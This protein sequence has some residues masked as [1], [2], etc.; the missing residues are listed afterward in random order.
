[1]SQLCSCCSKVTEPHLLLKCCICLQN[2]NH[3]CVNITA[4]ETRLINGKKS[5][6][7]TC[8]SCDQMG[9]DINSLKAAIVS[10]QNQLKSITVNN[11]TDAS[12]STHSEFQ[13]EEIVQEVVERQKRQ[14]NIIIF[15][16]KEQENLPKEDRIN[17]EKE[18]VRNILYYISPDV[19]VKNIQRL[20]KYDN[21]SSKPRLVKVSLLNSEQAIQVLR[22]SPNLKKNDNLK[23]IYLSSDQT[24]SQISYYKKVKSEL[25]DRIKAGE[26]NL[27]IKHINGIPKIVNF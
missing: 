18:D 25:E 23:N 11:V 4:S 9:S 21:Q 8:S 15:G 19:T 3:S 5:V 26:E 16:M 14:S 1:M 24:P 6:T 22:K 17:A 2:F 10:L 20:G 27:K 7:W 13:F 12:L